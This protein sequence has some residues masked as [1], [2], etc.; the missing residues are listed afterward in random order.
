MRIG[1]I[2]D[3]HSNAPALEEVLYYL[4]DAGV[5]RIIHAGDVIGYNPFPNEVVRMLI[6][7]NVEGIKGN[8]EIILLTEDTSRASYPA[9]RAIEWT[10]K[11]LSDDSWKYLKSLS[12]TLRFEFEGVSL[13]LFHGSPDDVWRYVDPFFATNE[14]LEE[15]G[16]DILVLG[17]THKPFVKELKLGMIVNPGAVGQP[18]DGDWRA[19]LAIL[20]PKK[21]EAKIVRL[22]YDVE[23]IRSKIEE[24]GLPQILGN[25]LKTGR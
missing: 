2:S 15:V 17:H 12:D 10:K 13:A 7:H 14:M 16:T 20:E 8:H 19:S 23:A 6:D 24:I 4:E 11:V 1:L 9:E 18:R 21:M 3:V 22:P 25:R 5:D